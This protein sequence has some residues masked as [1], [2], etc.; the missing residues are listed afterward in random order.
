MKK[1]FLFGVL[2]AFILTVYISSVFASESTFDVISEYSGDFLTLCADGTDN[3]IKWNEAHDRLLISEDL[4]KI[5]LDADVIKDESSV[6][7]SAKNHTLCFECG[8]EYYIFDGVGGRKIGDLAAVYDNKAYL[9]LRYIFEA[10]GAA[11][12]Y[13]DAAEAAEI[14]KNAFEVSESA[15]PYL[16]NISVYDQS[17]VRITGEKTVYFDPRRIMGE[18]HDADIIFI[19]HTHNDH[20]EIDSI[21]K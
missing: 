1:I 11:V 8:S 14:N 12:Y 16:E 20:Y 13:N 6:T 7:V 19:T 10:F 18:S 5:C 17:T 2:S 21:K 4:I 3:N 15:E 9:P